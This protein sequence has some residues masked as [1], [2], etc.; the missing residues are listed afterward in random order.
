[1]RIAALLTALALAGCATNT[2]VLEVSPDT[3]MLSRTDKGGIFGDAS[4]MKQDVIREA[5]DFAKAQGKIA[6]P[7]SIKEVPL[8]P[9]R[10][11]SVEY[12]FRVVSRDDPE[13]RRTAIKDR[14][15]FVVERNENIKTDAG[16]DPYADLMKLDDLRKRGIVTD[17]E[18]ETQKRRLLGL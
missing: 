6:I 10:F 14:A 3:Y 9:G 17:A 16:K 7:V 18:F 12:Q 11:A 13:A 15:D 2:G 4:A 8:R 5:Q 1:M